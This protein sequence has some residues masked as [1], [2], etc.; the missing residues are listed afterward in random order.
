MSSRQET[1]LM[2]R[3]IRDD[4]SSS[5]SSGLGS[6]VCGSSIS[7]INDRTLNFSTASMDEYNPPI[8][9]IKTIRDPVSHRIIEKRRRD[10]MNNCLAELS[11]LLPARYLNKGQGRIEKTEIIELA[12]HHIKH[13]NAL[14]GSTSS[15][16]CE[17]QCCRKS[18]FLGFKESGAETMRFLV[19][20]A[21]TNP[22]DNL[23][24]QL[25]QHLN[26]QSE[27]FCPS[28]EE[29]GV[30]EINLD[31]EIKESS[32]RQAAMFSD[33]GLS[34]SSVLQ[35][36]LLD[37]SQEA[38]LRHL[39]SNKKAED[40]SEDLVSWNSCSQSRFSDYQSTIYSGENGDSELPSTSSDDMQSN[41][42]KEIYK[43]K[44]NI[45]LRFTANEGSNQAGSSGQSDFSYSNSPPDS[46]SCSSQKLSSSPSS[47]ESTAYA[48]SDNS[49]SNGNG[50]GSTASSMSGSQTSDSFKNPKTDAKKLQRF[51]SLPVSCDEPVIPGFA[52]HPSATY[53]IPIAIPSSSLCSMLEGRLLNS[54]N[55]FHPISIPVQFSSSA[56]SL[57]NINVGY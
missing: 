6:S 54:S 32:E 9:R 13:L 33:S 44:N 8:K 22:Q 17:K 16:L 36:T 46:E 55:V 34:D 5:F 24:V 23:C 19:E 29:L 28:P 57:K 42:N 10:R 25:R 27:K 12:T 14:V 53:Y 51:D 49:S 3:R 15:K 47:S 20:G 18:F 38:R 50:L 30:P 45:K 43:F 31:E 7:S 41:K 21:G 1:I 39:F 48:N 11:S 2:D 4:Q 26:Q 56:T 52:L 37:K 40:L 35:T